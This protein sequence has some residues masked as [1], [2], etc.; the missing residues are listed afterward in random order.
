MAIQGCQMTITRAGEHDGDEGDGGAAQQ[1]EALLEGAHGDDQVE[2]DGRGQVADLQV[3]DHD[4]AEQH[5]VVKRD[6]A[7]TVAKLARRIKDLGYDVQ[8]QVAA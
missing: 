8:Y 4:Q 5:L 3:E 6:A 1:A 2:A 7:A